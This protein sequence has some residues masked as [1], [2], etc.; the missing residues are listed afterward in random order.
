MPPPRDPPRPRPREVVPRVREDVLRDR[1]PVLRDFAVPLAGDFARELAP[2]EDLAAALERFAPALDDFARLVV[3]LR[4]LVLEVFPRDA[5]D[6]ERVP[7]DLRPPARDE[8]EAEL[9]PPLD[10]SSDAHLPDSTRC[11]ASATASAISEPSF[12]ALDIT[13]V[14][15]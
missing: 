11:A 15:A 2:V 4:A 14:A 12:V 3:D 5:D 10:D 1:V 8:L 13:L 7:A 6:L 9:L